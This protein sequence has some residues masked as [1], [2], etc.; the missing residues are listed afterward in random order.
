M[1]ITQKRINEATRVIIDIY[2]YISLVEAMKHHFIHDDIDM[3]DNVDEETDEKTPI[4]EGEYLELT[5]DLNHKS[6][7]SDRLNIFMKD[8]LKYIKTLF[9]EKGYNDKTISKKIDIIVDI[10]HNSYIKDVDKII[11]R[12]SVEFSIVEKYLNERLENIKAVKSS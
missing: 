10:A 3:W 4:T 12:D 11:N 7:M 9:E 6:K 8:T 5:N 1:D 2:K